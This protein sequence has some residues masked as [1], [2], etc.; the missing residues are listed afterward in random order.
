MF[1]V[2]LAETANV[3]PQVLLNTEKSEGFAPVIAMLL[4]VSVV[5][6]PFVSVTTFC[7]PVDPTATLAQERLVGEADTAAIAAVPLSAH[8]AKASLRSGTRP[9]SRL[10]AVD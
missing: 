7:P 8:S 9:L 3:V 2:Q 6:P 1:A 4:I 5:V 10:A